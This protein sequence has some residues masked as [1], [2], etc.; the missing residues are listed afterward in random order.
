MEFR[1]PVLWDTNGNYVTS[2]QLTFFLN[3]KPNLK[4]IRNLHPD[5]KDFLSFCKFYN[6]LWDKMEEDPGSAEM[7]WDEESES[8]AFSF[9]KRGDIADYLLNTDDL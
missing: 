8:I 2:A 6:F 5:F 1:K 4:K 3:T 9:P 7:Y